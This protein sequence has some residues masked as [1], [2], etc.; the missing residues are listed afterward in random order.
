MRFVIVFVNI[1]LFALSSFANPKCLEVFQKTDISESPFLISDID[2]LL[3]DA[4]K[5]NTFEKVLVRT[6][7]GE[8]H[9][10]SARLIALLESA[11]KT[12]NNELSEIQFVQSILSDGNPPKFSQKEFFD[13]ILKGFVVTLEAEANPALGKDFK[14]SLA[15][16]RLDDLYYAKEQVEQS[17][18]V[19]LELVKQLK[20]HVAISQIETPAKHRTQSII[21]KVSEKRESG[22]ISPLIFRSDRHS[23]GDVLHDYH[24]HLANLEILWLSRILHREPIIRELL[25]DQNADP[26]FNEIV[27]FISAFPE[28]FS[29]RH[30]IEDLGFQ[31]SDY[32]L[33]D[34]LYSG[35]KERLLVL[36]KKFELDGR[37]FFQKRITQNKEELVA[38]IALGG[39]GYFKM[40]ETDD[41]TFI[42]K[43]PIVFKSFLSENTDLPR[44]EVK[45]EV[46]DGSGFEILIDSS[47]NR[48]AEIASRFYL[49]LRD[50]VKSGRSIL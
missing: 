29:V 39:D 18:V 6:P 42:S 31:F 27:F 4:K 9:I 7:L 37:I 22:E 40:S 2:K 43:V 45:V 34:G 50:Q 48:Q 25:S 17:D 26:N 24:S 44:A 21:R 49:Y 8:A 14:D 46:N 13:W 11:Q 35:G 23:W 3:T 16:S 41:S 10:S 1:Y 15:R 20:L 47:S 5:K 33:T 36:G 12:Q 32:R 28:L 19:S 38:G 30:R